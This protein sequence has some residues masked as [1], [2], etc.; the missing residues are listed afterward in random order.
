MTNEP[1]LPTLDAL[2]ARAYDC[3]VQIESWQAKLRAINSAI[4][5]YKEPPPADAGTDDLGHG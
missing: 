4:A 1:L 5:N 3:V 2:K